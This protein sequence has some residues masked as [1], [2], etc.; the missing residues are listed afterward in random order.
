MRVRDLMVES[1]ITIGP[2]A[3]IS[4][5][6]HLMKRSRIRHLPVVESSGELRGFVT[7]ADLKEG[8]L[9]SM[10]GDVALADL[11]I[12]DPVTVAPDDSLETAARRIYHHKISGMPVAVRNRLAGIITETDILRAFIQMMGILNSGCRVDVVLGH[13][14]ENLHRA[15][16]IAQETGAEV[17][18]LG[19]TET[20]GQRI[21]HLRLSPCPLGDVATALAAA[22]F[23]VQDAAD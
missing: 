22:G 8:L 5:A 12:A 21:G 4:D 6:L 20:G 7:L 2:D 16:R 19:L 23:A 10:V 17:L 1:P 15:V 11:M 14:P 13:A 3:A 9:P 18:S